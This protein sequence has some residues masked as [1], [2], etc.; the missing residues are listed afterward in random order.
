MVEL[1]DR[2]KQLGGDPFRIATLDDPYAVNSGSCLRS[3]SHGRV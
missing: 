1:F 2:L 3:G